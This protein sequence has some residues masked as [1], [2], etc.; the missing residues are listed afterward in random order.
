MHE[1]DERLEFP[2][3]GNNPVSSMISVLSMLRSYFT[4]AVLKLGSTKSSQGFLG[5]MAAEK[6]SMF[7][8]GHPFVS[9]SFSIYTF[10]T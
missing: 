1:V 6:M 9:I 5:I 8:K 10:R 2:T 7:L 3:N 4:A